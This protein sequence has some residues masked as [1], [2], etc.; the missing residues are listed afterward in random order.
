[1]AQAIGEQMERHGLDAAMFGRI[2]R[3]TNLCDRI[4]FDLCFEAPT[5]DVVPVF[6]RNDRDEEIAV[7]YRP[8]RCVLLGSLI[9]SLIG[10][11]ML[12]WLL[13]R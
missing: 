5:A 2:D 1:M 3:I 4:A 10:T 7:H 8:R 13:S 11:A 6:P 9:V 12:I